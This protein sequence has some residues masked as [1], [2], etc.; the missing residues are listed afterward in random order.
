MTSRALAGGIV[1]LAAGTVACVCCSVQAADLPVRP[2]AGAR[3]AGR[4]CA[5][6]LQ[7]D[8][9]L[10]RRPSSAA[11]FEDSSWSDPF[12]RAASDTFNNARLPRRRPESACNTSIQL[13]RRSGLEGDFTWAPA[14][15]GQPAREPRSA[16]RSTTSRAIG[17]R[18]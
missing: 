8:R 12:T 6:G 4:L 7:L 5:T 15:Q 17:P 14:H 10:C 1:A 11:D 18:P 13:A 3:G 2:S 16:T 9:I